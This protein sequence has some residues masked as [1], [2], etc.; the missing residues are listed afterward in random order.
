MIFK[1]NQMPISCCC[2]IAKS[3]LT[4]HDSM[5]CNTPGFPV[6]HHLP[7]I[8][9]VHVCW[10]GNTI[11][12]S[13]FSWLQSFPAS[14][15]FIMTQ[16]FASGGQSLGASASVLPKSIQGWFPLRLTGLIS[17]LPR[18]F[19]ESSLAPVWKHQFFDAQPSKWS[20]FHIHTW[21]LE[22]TALTIRTFFQSE[23]SAF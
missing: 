4:I 9:Q 2:S 12:P 1:S 14:G 21:L 18:D 23:V 8:A 19:Q 7:E 11:Q 15:S 3:Y 20:N 5:D 13:L 17:L 22:K 16:L 10:I 6:P